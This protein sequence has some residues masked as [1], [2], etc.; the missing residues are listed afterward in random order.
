MRCVMENLEKYSKKKNF[1]LSDKD[2]WTSEYMK[3]MWEKM[4]EKYF[5]SKFGWQNRNVDMSWE[6]LYKKILKVKVLI[7]G[8]DEEEEI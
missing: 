6:T 8:E 7:Q 2:L 4:G 3:R 1:Y 5:I